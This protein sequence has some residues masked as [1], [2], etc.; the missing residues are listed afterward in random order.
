MRSFTRLESAGGLE[1]ISNEV[2]NGVQGLWQ[3]LRVFAAG[4]SEIAPAA[5]IAPDHLG[6]GL[7]QISSVDPALEVTRDR[8]DQG[9]FGLLST[10]ENHDPRAQLLP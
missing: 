5:T 1:L 3:L 8:N 6:D 4:L 10:A 9:H 2:C 7:G